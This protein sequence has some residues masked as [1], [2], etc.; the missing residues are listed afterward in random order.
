VILFFGFAAA[1]YLKVT[2]EITPGRNIVVG[3]VL[4]LGWMLELV[5]AG[6]GIAG[7]FDKSSKKGFPIAGLAIGLSVLVTSIAMIMIGIAK[8]RG[9][10][11]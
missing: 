8:A 2:G 11:P 1:A 6:L 4:F 7:L 3:F 5:A 10:F 9:E